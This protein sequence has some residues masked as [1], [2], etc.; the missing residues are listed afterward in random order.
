MDGLIQHAGV[1]GG[2][3]IAAGRE[4]QP[5]VIIRA[6]GPHTPTGWGMP[7]MLDIAFLELARCTEEQM[8]THKA[9]LGVNECHHVLQLIA[10]P[11]SAR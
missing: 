2:A 7:P 5:E 3:D 9:R 11:E 1:A 10:K 8:R 4:R 6:M